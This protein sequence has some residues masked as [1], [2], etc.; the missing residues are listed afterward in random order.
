MTTNL[1][2]SARE[3]VEAEPSYP[4]NNTRAQHREFSRVEGGTS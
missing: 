3:N 1:V 2:I 4:R